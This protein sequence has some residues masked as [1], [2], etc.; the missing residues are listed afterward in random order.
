MN[1]NQLSVNVIEN[2]ENHGEQ[3]FGVA[4]SYNWNDDPRRLA[5]SLSRYKFVAKMFTNKSNVLEVGCAD[6][7]ASRIVAQSVKNLSGLDIV[8]EHIISANKIMSKNWPINFFYHDMLSG[9]VSKE[10]GGGHF[11]AAYS[12]DVLEHIDPNL[13]EVFIENIVKSLR[14]HAQLI[15][16]MPSIESQTFASELSKVGHINCK[17]QSDL[18]KTM[19]KYF[20]HVLTFCFN[21][22]VLH[23]GYHKMA[24]YNIAICL[25]Q[26]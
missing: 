18:K 5:F 21:D 4:S 17:T 16:G 24:H 6:G 26:Y 9:P 15:I 12:L 11:D 20:K 14:P 8:E 19:E 22:E 7:F 25:E 1:T 10:N 23:T 3:K 2:I 13:E